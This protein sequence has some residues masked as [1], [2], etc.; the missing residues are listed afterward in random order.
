MKYVVDDQEEA[1]A[2]ADRKGLGRRVR[3][4]APEKEITLGTGSLLG[5][6]FGLVLVC[7]IFFGLGYTMGRT[8]GERVAQ[9]S[10]DTS[11]VA[12]NGSSSAK[13]SPQQGTAPADSEASTPGTSPAPPASG[14]AGTSANSESSSPTSD[15]PAATATTATSPASGNSAAT[16]APAPA[17]TATNQPATVFPSNPGTT[18][19][20]KVRPVEQRKTQTAPGKLMVQVAAVSRL[21]DA[22][23]L[24][25]AL[26]QR[27]FAAVVK[28]D[29]TD[30]LLHVQIGPYVTRAQANAVRAQ[31][32]ADGYNAM[33]K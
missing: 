8:A 15:V 32:L 20:L 24:V 31:L 18:P 30:S 14:A 6:F 22:T 29:P 17:T 12:Q 2:P 5:L 19:P 27:G 16:P 3:N 26:Q 13:P 1:E 7:G 33:I 23:V 4:A 9:S 10:T 21:K 28:R 25:A 11:A